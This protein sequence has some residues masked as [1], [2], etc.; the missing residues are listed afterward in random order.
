[1]N[2]GQETKEV[3]N[4]RSKNFN[5]NSILTCNIYN[6]IFHTKMPVKKLWLEKKINN[7]KENQAT[8]RYRI[9]VI[10]LLR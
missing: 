10:F 4:P 1:M 8:C 3:E 6:T 9:S 5:L 7:A 2:V